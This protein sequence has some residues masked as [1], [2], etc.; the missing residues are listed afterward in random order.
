MDACTDRRLGIHASALLVVYG[1]RRSTLF[2]GGAHD[3][4]SSRTP[5]LHATQW[6]AHDVWSHPV[7]RAVFPRPHDPRDP[8]RVSMMPGLVVSLRDPTRLL[9]DVWSCPV[10]RAVSLHQQYPHQPAVRIRNASNQRRPH[11]ECF[12]PQR[13]EWYLD[14]RSHG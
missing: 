14:H 6:G 5:Y 3:V 12:F 1:E 10:C 4:V 13:R 8:M 2:H 7:R 9:H 11:Q